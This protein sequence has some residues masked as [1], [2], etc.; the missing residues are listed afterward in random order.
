MPSSR[1]RETLALA[2]LP[3]SLAEL[4]ADTRALRLIMK[5]R[6][7]YWGS[8]RPRRQTCNQCQWAGSGAM[9]S[10]PSHWHSQC[11][12]QSRRKGP[13]RAAVQVT[14][15]VA[16]RAHLFT[17][18]VVIAT[19]AAGS[20]RHWHGTTTNARTSWTSTQ[21]GKTT[22]CASGNGVVTSRLVPA[23]RHLKVKVRVRV[24][25]AASLTSIH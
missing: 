22:A 14:G 17:G 13:A 24:L 6:A 16:L 4:F 1:S 15:T 5:R 7:S 19:D 18:I 9:S 10:C 23:T 11:H 3:A 25:L 8:S 2:R 20:S 21:A 12:W